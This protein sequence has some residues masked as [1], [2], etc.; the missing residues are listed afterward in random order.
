MIIT[1]FSRKRSSLSWGSLL[2]TGKLTGRNRRPGGAEVVLAAEVAR[3]FMLS[4]K[5]RISS[6]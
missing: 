3:S 2:K 1:K 6:C 4:A 5:N